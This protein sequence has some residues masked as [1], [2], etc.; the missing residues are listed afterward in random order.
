MNVLII[1][2]GGREH[3][4]AWK[5]AQ[6]PQVEKIWVAPGN[7]GTGQESKTQNV[8]ISVSD[9]GGLID[10]AKNHKINLT[11]VGSEVPLATGIVDYFHQENLSIFGPTQ[12]AAQLETSKIF[13]KTFMDR[14]G[15][16]TAAFKTFKKKMM[17]LTT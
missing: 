13:C 17:L 12:S 5:V 3:A 1:G 2:N 4:L 9:I 14:H 11:L 6:S 10:F 7:G 15:I 8:P 16:P